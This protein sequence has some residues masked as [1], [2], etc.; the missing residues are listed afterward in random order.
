MKKLL[1]ISGI[2]IASL[3][4]A[5]KT[6]TL[7]DEMIREAVHIEG[8]DAHIFIDSQTGPGMFLKEGD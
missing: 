4:N 7:T 5:I 3:S 6:N 8:P 1:F 2:I